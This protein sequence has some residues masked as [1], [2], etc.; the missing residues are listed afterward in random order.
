MSNSPDVINKKI[1]IDSNAW[2][3]LHASGIDL[4]C[5]DLSE[6]EF[7]ITLEI[8]RELDELKGRQDKEDLYNY[9]LSQTED[10]E[11][12]AYFGF[13]DP[14]VPEDEQRNA[15]FGV[16]G[17]ASIFDVQFIESNR[18]HIKNK[19]RKIYYVNEADL[20]IASRAG[21][22]TFI[23]TEDNQKA[24]PL[25]NLPNTIKVSQSS[26]L[27]AHDFKKLLDANT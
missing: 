14:D 17:F 11:P 5:S 23:L 18:H 13:H 26:P 8:K 19:K 3:F 10:M 21:N 22:G 25:Q 4:N 9:F 1:V 12:L 16:G 7:Q 24:G 27:T 2:N 15:G 6:Y 20:L